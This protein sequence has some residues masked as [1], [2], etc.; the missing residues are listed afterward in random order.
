MTAALN[1]ECGAHFLD[2][3]GTIVRRRAVNANADADAGAL[4]IADRAA[5]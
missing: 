5:A 3:I 2:Q 1:Q 4:Q